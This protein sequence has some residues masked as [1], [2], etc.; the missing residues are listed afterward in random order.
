MSYLDTG[1]PAAVA[2]SAP[3]V[4]AEFIKKTYLHLAMAIAAF[5]GLEALYINLGWG[6]YAMKLLSVH[7]YAW[8]GVLLVYGF[9][10]HFMNKWAHT[11]VTK[12]QQYMALAGGVVIESLIFL[13][14]IMIAYS[15][16]PD[17]LLNAAVLTLGLVAGL[18]AAVIFTGKDFKFLAP[19]LTI[20]G[21][22]ALAL[23]VASIL[24]GF[25]LGLWF[26]AIMIVFASAAILYHTSKI[27]KEYSEHQYIGAALTLFASVGLLFWYV[28]QVLLSFAG[29]D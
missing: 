7:S 21:F 17:V 8:I 23:I 9:A 3:N 11:S 22:V 29:E 26:S 6:E 18:T 28:L 20:V 15:Y 27:F 4:R 16:A 2:H 24:F 10:S 19:V 13:P 25:N 12:E 1:H 14:M 5:A